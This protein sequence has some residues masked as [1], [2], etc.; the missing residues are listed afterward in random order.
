MSNP[1]LKRFCQ[2]QSTSEIVEALEGLKR[3]DRLLGVPDPSMAVADNCCFVRAAVKKPMPEISVVLDV[4]HFMKRYLICV[5][6]GT[7]NPYRQDVARDIIDAILKTPADN[8][9]QQEKRLMEAYEKWEEKG[10]V[11]SAA[12][13]KAHEEQLSHVRKGCLA[14]PRQDIASDGSH[15]E[16]SH[17]G[18]N[19]L[20]RSFASGIEVLT[21]LGH[22]HVLRRNIRVA[23]N[24]SHMSLEQFLQ[25]TRGSHHIRL[26]DGVAKLWNVILDD[27]KTV[28]TR[29][30]RPLPELQII[31]S[32]ETFGLI[33]AEYATSYHNLA[34][35]KEEPYEDLLDLSELDCPDADEVLRSIDPEL[36]PQ[37][38]KEPVSTSTVLTDHS[39]TPSCTHHTEASSS[40]GSGSATSPITIEAPSLEYAASPVAVTVTSDHMETT[41]VG[42]MLP[43]LMIKG[44]TRSQQIFSITTSINANSLRILTDT[45][46][47]LFMDMRV[48]G[49]WR[50]F[51]MTPR[52]WVIA[53][54]AYNTRLEALNHGKGLSTI[55]KTPRAL[56]DKLGELEPKILAHITAE[57]YTCEFASVL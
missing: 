17:K 53:A 19:G 18:W 33:R 10:G 21:A 57:D 26:V 9:E 37:P 27:T 52:K 34:D 7:K 39:D 13:A 36:C 55:R 29:N 51:N 1:F 32:G 23:F 5:N 49:K 24:S 43:S 15:I 22:D 2:S 12:A 46:F 14:R 25:S 31:D 4:W 50:S 48:E 8:K 42:Q 6:N 45:E 11:W 44:L 30:L 54:E 3:R 16:G 56:M 47:Y 28:R 38:V 41:A 40:S 20:Q 35:I